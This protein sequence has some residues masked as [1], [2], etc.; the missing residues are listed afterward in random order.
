MAAFRRFADQ[1]QKMSLQEFEKK[2]REVWDLLVGARGALAQ[3]GDLFFALEQIT[4][5]GSLK[6]E[7]KQDLQSVIT[8]L[9]SAHTKLLIDFAVYRDMASYRAAL[10]TLKAALPLLNKAEEA[11]R[12]GVVYEGEGQLYDKV[13]REAA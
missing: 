3:L 12:T 5:W 10:G 6:K 2:N 8:M 11:V 7:T 9:K 4:R 1:A 13:Y